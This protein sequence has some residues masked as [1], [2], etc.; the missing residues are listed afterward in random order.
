M[1]IYEIKSD[2]LDKI[3]ETTFSE[4][5]VRE[6]RDLQRLLRNQIEVIDEDVLVIAEEFGDFEDSKR[7]ID[8]LGIDREA[9]LVV[10][11]LK[12]TEDGG[13]MELQALRY[14]A[15]VSTITFENALAIYKE[16]LEANE[17]QKNAEQEIL[18]HLGW[19]EPLE[20]L[21]AQDVRVILAS[22][23]FSKE[24]TS[25]V[26]WLNTYGLDIRC[27]RLKPYKDNGRILVDIEQVIPLPEASEYQIQVSSKN[28]QERKSRNTNKDFSKFDITIFG[29]LKTNLAKRNGI[30]HIVKSLCDHGI[31]SEKIREL[32]HWRMGRL[33]FILD[34][35]LSS[36]QFIKEAS[37]KL[38][39]NGKVFDASRWFCEEGELIIQNGKTYAFSNQWGIRWMEAINLLKDS[40]PEAK[41]EIAKS[42]PEN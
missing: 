36:E 14:A 16:Y 22:A 32:I 5:G 34:G 17:I 24:I 12:R 1:P 26:L 10:I 40:F 37:G 23:E 2:Y 31:S 7:R 28:R 41:I 15:M 19:D 6:R 25:T 27:V 42:Q 8:L 21:F 18:N 9:R 3:K 39:A 38:G 30:F 33:F 11:E 4:S 20:D 35:T 13:H 29:E